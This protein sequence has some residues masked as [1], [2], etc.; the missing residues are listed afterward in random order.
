MKSKSCVIVGI[1]CLSTLLASAQ[2]APAPWIETFQASPA[3]VTLPP[4]PPKG[5]PSGPAIPALTG[6]IQGTIRCRIGIWIGGSRLQV[7]IQTNWAT[8]H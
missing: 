7:K 1:F 8:N 2:R 4:P 6:P 3:S 5:M